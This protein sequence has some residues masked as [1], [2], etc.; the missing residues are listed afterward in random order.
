MVYRVRKQKQSLLFPQN[1]VIFTSFKGKEGKELGGYEWLWAP[2]TYLHGVAGPG[3]S[4]TAFLS[5]SAFK[6]AKA[7]F[8]SSRDL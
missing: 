1:H 4:G 5:F 3:D 8:T 7:D 6:A 2:D